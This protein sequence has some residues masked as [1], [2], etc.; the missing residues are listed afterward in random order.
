MTREPE[1]GMRSSCGQRNGSSWAEPKGLS[2]GAAASDGVAESKGSAP[3]PRAST[4][5]SRRT[6]GG[7]RRDIGTSRSQ[8]VGSVPTGSI[9]PSQ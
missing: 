1:H 7:M 6:D 3:A 4:W 2:A 8:A 5:A 9:A